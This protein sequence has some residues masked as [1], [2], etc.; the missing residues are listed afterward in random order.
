MREG[1]EFLQRQA[2]RSELLVV[3]AIGALLTGWGVHLAVHAYA[4]TPD[5][6]NFRHYAE[7]SSTKF[8]PKTWYLFGPPLFGIVGCASLLAS[9]LEGGLEVKRLHAYGAVVFFV[10]VL[11]ACDVNASHALR[12]AGVAS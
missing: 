8:E 6:L 10:F 4:A 11:W 9:I 1:L 2:A 12:A 3:L 7:P 5:I